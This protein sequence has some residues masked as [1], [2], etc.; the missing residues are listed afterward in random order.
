MS[1]AELADLRDEFDWM[2]ELIDYQT[3]KHKIALLGPA[4]VAGQPAHALEVTK[5][6]GEVIHVFID[7]KTGLE[8]QRIRWA[9]SPSGEGAEFVLPIG[10]Y[11][12]VGGLMLPHRVGPA[13]RTYEVN[14]PIPDTRFQ[15]PGI[16]ERELAAATMTGAIETP[17]P[18]R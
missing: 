17:L 4:T 18:G 8:V 15:R 13:S 3:K 12:P 11:R 16:S 2:F 5:A 1:A 6:R 14:G 10:D 7:V 9:Q